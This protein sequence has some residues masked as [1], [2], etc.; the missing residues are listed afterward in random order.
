MDRRGHSDR[1]LGGSRRLRLSLRYPRMESLFSSLRR[2]RVTVRHRMESLF[3]RSLFSLRRHR[4]R[5]RRRRSL[6]RRRSL[7]RL[8]LF[9]LS[10]SLR[11][12]RVTVRHRMESLRRSRRLVV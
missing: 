4:V 9:S 7:R 11:R 12:H 8:S 6:H 2:H 1:R 5:H 3:S 10:S